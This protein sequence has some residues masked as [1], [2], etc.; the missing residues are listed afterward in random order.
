MNPL[1]TPPLLFLTGLVAGL[2]SVAV[3]QLD[4]AFL[5]RVIPVLL[6]TLRILYQNYR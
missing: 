3:Q 5:R 6:I 2:G 4:P 1:W